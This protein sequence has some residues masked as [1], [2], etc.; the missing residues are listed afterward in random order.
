VSLEGKQMWLLRSSPLDLSS[1][2]WSKYWTGTL[3]LLTLAL[4]ITAG[5]NLLLRA[6]D[7]MMI[8][9]LVTVVL[10]TFAIA[11]LALA[12]GAYYPR[13]DTENTAQIRPASAAH[14]H[15]DGNHPAGHGD[16]DRGLSGFVPRAANSAE[17][18]RRSAP[19][20]AAAGDRRGRLRVTD[21]AV[22]HWP[23]ANGS[24]GVLGEGE[25]KK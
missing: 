3:P 15:D 8:L 12:F 21:R 13:F 25:S 24:H 18:P 1:L 2:L 20:G 16:H 23:A 11:A 7:F 9:S 10:L 17:P 4:A 19:Y 22:A 6:S 14:V 5:T